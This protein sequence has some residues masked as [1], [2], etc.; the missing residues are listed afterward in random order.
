MAAVPLRFQVLLPAP[1][2]MLAAVP[3]SSPDWFP[4]PAK[5]SSIPSLSMLSVIRR[6][7]AEVRVVWMRQPWCIQFPPAV[8]FSVTSIPPL[9]PI[10]MMYQPFDVKRC[11][12][13]APLSTAWIWPASHAVRLSVAD[14][15]GAVEITPA[16]V[17]FGSKVPEMS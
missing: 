10:A 8:A 2:M 4:L 15:K 11:R 12:R 1:S 17:A 7:I 9:P 13:P 16:K 14:N 3:L 5:M 6:R